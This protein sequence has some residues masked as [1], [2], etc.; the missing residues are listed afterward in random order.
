MWRAQRRY[1]VGVERGKANPKRLALWGF[2]GACLAASGFFTTMLPGSRRVVLG[3][4]LAQMIVGC[5][6]WLT[7]YLRLKRLDRAGTWSD[8]EL[9]PVRAMLAHPAWY[10]GTGGIFVGAL[11]IIMFSDH[12]GALL[13]IASLP[14][15]AISHIR[16]ALTPAMARAGA[17]GLP[18]VDWAGMKP[19]HSE[20]WGE[21]RQGQ[22]DVLAH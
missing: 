3:V 22:G 4:F 13:Y 12:H 5:G 6:V 14:L 16:T 11:V 8:E 15:N 17:W 20:H 21:A 10:W 9:A 7:A 18:V 2:A 1:D 19:I